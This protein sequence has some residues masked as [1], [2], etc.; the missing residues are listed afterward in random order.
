MITLKSKYKIKNNY[1]DI[2]LFI[3][4]ISLLIIK[5]LLIFFIGEDDN[6]LLSE[7]ENEWGKLFIS[8]KNHGYMSWFSTNEILFRNAFMPPLYVYFIYI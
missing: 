8:L 5:I 4:L 7:S 2:K 1:K 3:L 6:A